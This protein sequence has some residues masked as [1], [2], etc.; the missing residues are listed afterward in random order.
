MP[1]VTAN[2]IQIEYDT[3]GD[4]SN[5]TI[6]MIIGIGLQMIHWDEP[7]CLRLAESGLFVIRFDNRDAGLSSK[8]EEAGVPDL[9]QVFTDLMQGKKIEASYT[10]DDMA[11]DSVGLL[12]AL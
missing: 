3:F 1:N 7:L 11:N 8:M 4:K 10:F 9:T 12:D 5:P 2:G 6:L